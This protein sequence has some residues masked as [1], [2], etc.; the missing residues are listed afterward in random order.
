MPLG[1]SSSL[2]VSTLNSVA[3]LKVKLTAGE[4]KTI[5]AYYCDGYLRHRMVEDGPM[6]GGG[7]VIVLHDHG[8]CMGGL[9]IGSNPLLWR[10]A[11]I[12]AVRT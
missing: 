8:V 2:T 3:K 6:N 1:V 10:E 11:S 9:F 5:K 7:T 4:F 12:Q